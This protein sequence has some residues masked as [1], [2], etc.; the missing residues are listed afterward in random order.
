M[1]RWVT[2]ESMNLMCQY[3]KT[4]NVD[5]L[6]KMK[7]LKDS[8]IQRLLWLSDFFQINDFQI[9]CL[10]KIIIPRLNYQN[11]IVYLNEAFK[12]L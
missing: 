2:I 10:L 12:K 11:C 7:N 3:F 5:F 8:A 4:G 9:M 1:P 6:K